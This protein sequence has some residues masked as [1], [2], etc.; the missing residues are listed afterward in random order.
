[1][2]LEGLQLS[3]ALPFHIPGSN[4][5]GPC[6]LAFV[7]VALYLV[8]H[9][10]SGVHRHICR[11]YRVEPSKARS[12][13]VWRLSSHSRSRGA[14]RMVAFVVALCGVYG[15][16]NGVAEHVCL[17]D[18]PSPERGRSLPGQSLPLP[19]DHACQEVGKAARWDGRCVLRLITKQAEASVW[20]HA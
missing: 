5:K 7:R 3:D 16:R 19:F 17:L 20:L 6:S 11:G 13:D 8:Y 14:P 4:R 10:G 18:L 15:C 12:F 2:H 9:G 1:M